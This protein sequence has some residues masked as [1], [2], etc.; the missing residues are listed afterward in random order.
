MVEKLLIIAYSDN[1]FSKEAG[2]FTAQ[3][4]PEK[5][6]EDFEVRFE[7]KDSVNPAGVSPRY[8]GHQPRRL[9]LDFYL[10]G[11]GAVDSTSVRDSVSAKQ[12]V[13]VRLKQFLDV[14]YQF[15]GSIHR[16]RYVQVCWGTL[17]FHCVLEKV[18]VDYTLFDPDG[19]PLRA[20]VTAKF[21]NFASEKKLALKA[22]KQSADLT[23]YRQ[24]AAGDTLPLMCYKVYGDASLYVE[25]ARRNGLVNF[26]RLALSQWL[27]FPPRDQLL[28]ASGAG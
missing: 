3:I 25:V 11:T 4:N 23:N 7:S 13:S 17:A 6:S 5:Y 26:R 18:D 14:V 10:D 27:E 8:K 21:V 9:A 20:H 15:D 16:S 28:G 24:V 1:R 19:A 12:T 2:R 22:R